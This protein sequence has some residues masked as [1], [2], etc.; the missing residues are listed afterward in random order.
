MRI[1]LTIVLLIVLLFAVACDSTPQVVVKLSS[2]PDGSTVP[3]Q[4]P[5]LL[6]GSG[7]G[8]SV[9][10]VLVAADI[11][12]QKTI[13]D[14]NNI[15]E[16]RY[17]IPPGK[18]NNYGKYYWKVIASRGN[19]TSEWSATWSFQTASGDSPTKRGTV[20]VSATLDGAPWAGSVNY[21]LNGPF[22]DTDNSLPWSFT[23]LPLGTY[24]V[25]YNYGGPAGA[26]MAS[27]TPSPSQDLPGDGTLHFTLNFNKQFTSN[28]IVNATLNGAAWSGPLNY[29]ISG[30]S[31]TTATVVPQP[32]SN[33]PSGSYTLL[34]GSGGPPGA[35]LSGITP[36]A[37]QTL[38][39]NGSLVYTFSFSTQQTAG[40]V[41]INANLNGSPWSGTVNFNVTG[42]FQTSD[43][44]VPR[45]YA[46]IPAGNYNLNYMSGGPPGAT[47]RAITPAP[48]Q[49]LAGGRTVVFTLNF[50]M[51]QPSTGTIS[52]NALL[53]GQPWRVALGSGTISYSFT[54]PRS[55]SSNA[56]PATLSDIPAG[57]Y[58]LTFNGGGPV[59][60]TL[61]GIS[62][63]PL[64]NLLPGGNIT[65]TLQFTGQPKG[66]ITVN[67]VLNGQPWSGQVG[68][69]VQGPYVESGNSIP[70]SF[71]GAPSGTY[72][73]QY[74]VG[75]P[76]GAT[77]E[78]I[79]PPSQILPAGG[80]ATFTLM[81]KFQGLR[82]EPIPGPLPGPIPGPLK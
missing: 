51:S 61:T 77:F 44:V 8:A 56:M 18:L 14:A 62:P 11:N 52:V 70:W 17:I 65:F 42:P 12:F 57:Q 81:F 25:T 69:V 68:Y 35:I 27:I 76:P 82:P 50:V 47:L 28:I 34:Y 38:P 19:A 4:S 39:P 73:V 79:S 22:S 37:S 78:G 33:L 53:D 16:P 6:W 24:T 46:N 43:V 31:S 55:E 45:T 15:G 66:T 20:R 21:A 40:N 49:I 10:R 54:G 72:S 13:I 7:G 41:V 67:A 80:T 71:S 26:S 1:P 60:A 9:F 58:T 29:S 2:P 23:D 36:A 64:Q 59:G 5:V 63:T 30:P 74:R 3:S 32:F 48:S 75:G